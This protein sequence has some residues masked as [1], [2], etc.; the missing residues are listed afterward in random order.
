MYAPLV[1]KGLDITLFHFFV[2]LKQQFQFF[3]CGPVFFSER[4]DGRTIKKTKFLKKT[5]SPEYKIL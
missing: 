5:L 4:G 1:L 3:C 2:H